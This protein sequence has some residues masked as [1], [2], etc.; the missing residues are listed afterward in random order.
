MYGKK[1]PALLSLI[2]AHMGRRVGHFMLAVLLLNFLSTAALSATRTDMTDDFLSGE[3]S[4]VICTPQGLKRITLDE[5]G[6]PVSDDEASLEH[7]VYCL[8]FQKVVMGTAFNETD[9][10]VVD[11]LSY[12]LCYS[13]DVAILPDTPLK[14]SCPPRAPPQ[15]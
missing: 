12:K 10:P 8:P 14:A 5:N 2:L 3:Q 7:C 4:F 11:L 1:A 6:T 9:F 15:I 13:Y